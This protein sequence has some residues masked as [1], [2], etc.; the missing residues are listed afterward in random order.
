MAQDSITQVARRHGLILSE[1]FFSFKFFFG[2]SETHDYFNSILEKNRIER[3]HLYINSQIKESELINERNFNT[4]NYSTLSDY[5]KNRGI[6][7]NV[8]LEDIKKQ[9]PDPYKKDLCWILNFWTNAIHIEK[10][11]LKNNVHFHLKKELENILTQGEL[12][13]LVLVGQAQLDKASVLIDQLKK[14]NEE[15]QK[16]NA[17]LKQQTNTQKKISASEIKPCSE[18][19]DFLREA[20]IKQEDIN[21]E[22]RRG[23]NN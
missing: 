15:L 18:L 2:Q 22:K 8:L 4:I 14:E 11:A 6:S 5:L 3:A 13:G 19:M 17:K 10:W 7:L 12:K 9:L 20:E 23:I 1:F 16:E 21:L